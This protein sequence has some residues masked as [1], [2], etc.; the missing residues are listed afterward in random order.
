MTIDEKS[1]LIHVYSNNDTNMYLVDTV[2][3][4]MLVFPLG[5]LCLCHSDPGSCSCDL[6]APGLKD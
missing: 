2:L 4:Y 3:I 5:L 6:S 1:L